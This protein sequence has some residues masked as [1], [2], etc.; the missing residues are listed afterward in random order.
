MERFKTGSAK[1]VKEVNIEGG[2][3]IGSRYTNLLTGKTLCVK[4]E[5]SIDWREGKQGKRFT[6]RSSDCKAEILS[7]GLVFRSGDFSV[8]EVLSEAKS[9][10]I[11]KRLY[12]SMP[13]DV[14]IESVNQE[15]ISVK[16]KKFYWS[17][18]NAGNTFIPAKIARLGQPVYCGDMFFGQETPV[19]DNYIRWRKA[20]FVY[21]SGRTF[22]ELAENGVYSLPVFIAGAAK[23]ENMTA[24]KDAFFEYLHTVIRAPKFRIQ[25]NSWYDNKLDITSERIEKSFTAIAE[26]FAATG[27]RPLDCYVVDDGWTEYE[28]PVFWQFNKKF[29]GGFTKEALLTQKLGSKF[30]VWFGPRGG[31]TKQTYIYAKLLE[32][33][34]YHVNEASK[35]ICTADARYIKDLCER[36][37]EFCRLYNVDYFKIDGFAYAP[38]TET[39]HNHPPAEGDNTAFYTFLWENWLK[40]FEKIREANP[41]VCLNVT[42][43]AH[44]SP[45]FLTHADYIWMNNASD[46]EFV[47]KGSNMQK[48]LNYRD[49]RYRNLF[50]KRQYQFPAAY[51]Y[52]HEPTYARRNY[53]SRKDWEND[54]P[55]TYTDE[56]FA[57]YMK[58]CLMR[59]SGL[60]EL[61]F[62]PEMMT[63]GKWK[64][65]AKE[66]EYAEMHKDLLGESRFFG[67]RPER[68]KVYG[69]IAAK[70]GKYILMLRN[71]GNRPRR[72]RFD[73]PVAGRIEGKLAPQEIRFTDNLE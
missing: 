31:Y 68:G 21:H 60:A 57:L 33:I 43:Y 72:Y 44:C 58:C 10:V 67:G 63:E 34:G 2:R 30:G 40:G 53:A 1:I 66:L 51:M 71:S 64:A 65:A 26:G 8:K 73:L 29:E 4:E 59:G 18:P 16:G 56:E 17:A 32:Q 41:D 3:Y 46:M 50:V 27:L 49:G 13:S 61:Y 52:N 47:G 24:A 70:D 19:G 38:C 5:F 69:Y 14:F 6:L 54:K 62:S 35:D 36:M 12:L 11:E 39:G 20:E 45:W 37:A 55:I 23:A 22:E 42:S 28:K 15:E 48:C 9:G 25:Y 7:D